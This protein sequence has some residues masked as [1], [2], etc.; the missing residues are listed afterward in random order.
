MGYLITY[1]YLFMEYILNPN[2]HDPLVR[3][4]KDSLTSWMGWMM[5][6]SLFNIVTQGV[7]EKRGEALHKRD[8]REG[9]RE[10]GILRWGR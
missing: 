4:G 3:T 5:G 9:G 8:G 10:G 1:N 6:E 2:P 7:G